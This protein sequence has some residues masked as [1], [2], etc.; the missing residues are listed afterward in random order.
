MTTTVDRD[1]RRTARTTTRP[2]AQLIADGVVASYI[3]E[4]SQRH[5]RSADEERADV[6]ADA[7]VVVDFPAWTAPA[8]ICGFACV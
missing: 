1:L 2:S 7:G 4:I 5:G 6:E 3:H 8:V